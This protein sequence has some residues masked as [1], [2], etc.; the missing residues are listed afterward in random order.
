MTALRVLATMFWLHLKQMAVDG[1]V[2]FI[3]FVQPLIV[4]LAAIYM[5]RESEGFH[6]IFVIVGS[7]M[8]GLWSGTLFFCT[9]NVDRERWAGTLEELIGS[10]T[11]LRTIML[12]KSLANV[13]LSLGSM[14]LTY[15]LAALLFGYPVTIA[16]PLLFGVS[17]FLAVVA[18]VAVGMLLTPTVALNRGATAWNNTIEYP[19]YILGGFLFPVALLPAWTTPLSYLLPPYWAARALH[20]TSSGGATLEEILMS[21]TLLIVASAVCWLVSS[22][23]FR[24]V[25]R[26]ALVQATLGLQ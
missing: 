21:W 20:A 11:P 12:A 15:P 2:I 17:L 7:A 8:T 3:V 6:A 25:I 14:L 5:L 23:L 26:R 16:E 1:F 19:M 18:L 22:W 4:A 24:I 13:T 9:R 10:P